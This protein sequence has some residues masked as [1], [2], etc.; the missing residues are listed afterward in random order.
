MSN[1]NIEP[2][3]VLDT[4]EFDELQMYQRNHQ[5]EESKRRA[6]YVLCDGAHILE[7]DDSITVYGKAFL[8]KDGSVVQICDNK[9]TFN[10]DVEKKNF[11]K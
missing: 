8:I 4:T 5:L 11:S 7:T 9:E 6:I 1:I 10:I 2:H 3:F